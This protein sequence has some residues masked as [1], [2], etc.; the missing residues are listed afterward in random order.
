[1]KDYKRLTEKRET[2]L[3]MSQWGGTS[4]ELKIYNRLAKLEDDLESGKMI[5]LPCKV[6]DTVFVMFKTNDN[7]YYGDYLVLDKIGFDKLG[8]YVE[9]EK[10]IFRKHEIFLNKAEAEK[11]LKELQRE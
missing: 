9:T 4:R 6:G 7:L 10:G 2:P 1:M 3:V 8:F 5:R 11:R